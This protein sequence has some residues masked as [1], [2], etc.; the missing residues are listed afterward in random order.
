VRTALWGILLVHLDV[1][2]E[3]Q[4]AQDCALSPM[5]EGMRA[6]VRAP[7]RGAL[8]CSLLEILQKKKSCY[9]GADSRGNL[10]VRTNNVDDAM[11]RSIA[12]GS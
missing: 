10:P 5:H 12:G 3:C 11:S 7:A 4:Q 8:C 1:V 6:S 2:H 9:I